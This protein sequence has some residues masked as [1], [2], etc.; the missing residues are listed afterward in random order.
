M[1]LLDAPA[2]LQAAGQLLVNF[3]ELF[4]IRRYP[5][6]GLWPVTGAAPRTWGQAGR[7]GACPRFQPGLSS[8]SVSFAK[9][10]GSSSISS[11]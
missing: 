10:L 9:A 2:P 1:E 6:A 11:W 3:Q 8:R 4:P 7:R 5:R